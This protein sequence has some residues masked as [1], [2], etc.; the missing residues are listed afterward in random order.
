MSVFEL[1]WTPE[2]RFKVFLLTPHSPPPSVCADPGCHPVAGPGYRVTA[3]ARQRRPPSA[4]LAW[5]TN[6]CGQRLDQSQP[7]TASRDHRQPTTARP[8]PSRAAAA[9]MERQISLCRVVWF[10]PAARAPSLCAGCL[11]AAQLCS[12]SPHPLAFL[13]IWCVAE[14][15]H[16]DLMSTFWK[17]KSIAKVDKIFEKTHFTFK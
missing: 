8:A 2:N 3:R 5:L 13:S 6:E 1:S 16:F 10:A 14:F 12:V 11:E 7:S 4:P 17:Q 9:P 15:W